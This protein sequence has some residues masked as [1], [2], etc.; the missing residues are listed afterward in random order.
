VSDNI[1]NGGTPKLGGFLDIITQRA[2]EEA[3]TKHLPRVPLITDEQVRAIV[4]SIPFR[5]FPLTSEPFPLPMM[6]PIPFTPPLP[7]A[8]DRSS[9]Y[10]TR[11]RELRR[12]NRQLAKQS[13][14]L[15]AKLAAER[16]QAIA[17][18]TA[19]QRQIQYLYLGYSEVSNPPWTDELSL[20]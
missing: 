5:P 13:A 3:V 10:E 14:R 18:I 4:A 6:P 20:N 16:Q 8:P 2:L 12:R 7:I 17:T 19:L 9:E 1:R 15:A 11:I